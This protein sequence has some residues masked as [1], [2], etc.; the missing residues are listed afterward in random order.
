MDVLIRH[1]KKRGKLLSVDFVSRSYA[2]TADKSPLQRY[3]A[4]S[5][6]LVLEHE[7]SNTIEAEWPTSGVQKL[8][9]GFGIFSRDYILSTRNGGLADDPRES[10]KC[11]YHTHA[12][13]DPCTYGGFLGERKRTKSTQHQQTKRQ[14]IETRPSTAESATTST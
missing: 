4:R 11:D 3:V 14:C 6:Q 13:D 1:H 9:T 7:L 10:P 2:R 5:I 12:E 8:F